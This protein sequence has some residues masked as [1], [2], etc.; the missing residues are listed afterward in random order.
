MQELP[1]ASQAC[2]LAESIINMAHGLDKQVIAEGVETLEQLDFL[3]ERGCDPAQG[4]VLAR[5]LAVAEIS[6]LLAGRR[7]V[8]LP[9]HSAVG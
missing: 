1:A 9:G 5:P 8:A 6:E 3:R 4:Y 7:V 2:R